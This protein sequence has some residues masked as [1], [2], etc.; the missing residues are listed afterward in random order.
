[1]SA[2]TSIS[3]VSNSLIWINILE[4]LSYVPDCLVDVEVR[5]MRSS[6]LSS[7]IHPSAVLNS[8]SNPEIDSKLS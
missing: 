4:K 7:G 6:P 3:R 1:M 8:T 2:I 5:R